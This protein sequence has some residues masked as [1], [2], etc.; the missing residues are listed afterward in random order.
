MV[1]YG[2][3]FSCATLR[4]TCFFKRERG[5]ARGSESER[6]KEKGKG[7]NG[8]EVGERETEREKPMNNNIIFKSH[9][10]LTP[11]LKHDPLYHEK[12]YHAFRHHDSDPQN[13]WTALT[14]YL[15]AIIDTVAL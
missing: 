10:A 9:R 14:Y 13:D 12:T 2:T 6:E 5:R 3:S 7:G 1:L 4:L 15:R 11:V 8:G